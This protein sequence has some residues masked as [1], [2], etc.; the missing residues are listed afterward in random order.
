MSKVKDPVS[1][2]THLFSFFAS[3]IGLV[4]LLVLTKGDTRRQ[5]TMLIYG[6]SLMLLYGASS[7][8]HLVRTTPRK[9][10]F[11]RKLDH[12][13]IFILIAGCYTPVFY[14]GLT[15]IWRIVML[16]TIWGIALAGVILKM[17]YMKVPRAVSTSIYVIMGWIA[18][19]PF[20]HLVKTLPVNAIILMIMGGLL[21]TT[22]AVIYATKKWNPIPD[23]FGFHEIFHLFVMGG[24]LVHFLMI[25]QY[26][27]P[28]R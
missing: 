3:I 13:S 24:S 12:S 9:E 17:A 14:V 27:V 8:Y 28:L 20:V 6:I 10:L 19:V 23:K 25:L 16:S 18:V 2:F 7:T 21:Y 1:G 22:G 26:I 11:L 5:M 4:V 15:G